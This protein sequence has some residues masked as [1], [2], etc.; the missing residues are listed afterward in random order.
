MKWVE[1]SAP[2]GHLFKGLKK[3]DDEVAEMCLHSEPRVVHLVKKA[4]AVLKSMLQIEPGARP[5]CESAADRVEVIW[6]ESRVIV[7]GTAA[8]VP[9]PAPLPAFVRRPAASGGGEP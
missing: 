9:S 3:L 6:E 2:L 5:S 4:V 1:K 7:T 8:A